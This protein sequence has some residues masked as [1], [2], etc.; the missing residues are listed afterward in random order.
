VFGAVKYWDWVGSGPE[1]LELQLIE[2][3]QFVPDAVLIDAQTWPSIHHEKTI[4]LGSIKLSC[5]IATAKLK[6]VLHGRS[7]D[8]HIDFQEL[9]QA[10]KFDESSQALPFLIP[11]LLN[12]FSHFAIIGEGRALITFL[13]DVPCVFGGNDSN[14]SDPNQWIIDLINEEYAF[15]KEDKKNARGADN[16]SRTNATEELLDW[17][18]DWHRFMPCISIDQLSHT[19]KSETLCAM[20][21]C[22]CKQRWTNPE[23]YPAIAAH[24]GSCWVDGESGGRTVHR[25]ALI[26]TPSV[27][28]EGAFQRVGIAIYAQNGQTPEFCDPFRYAERKEITII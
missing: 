2:Q 17:N 6:S 7:R 4:P 18:Y 5:R 20:P 16:D 19:R 14:E 8:P 21:Y 1:N 24:I 13:P 15:V 27:F 3:S 25:F 28:Q 11:P 12:S 26:L 10:G 9:Y 22:A 23:E